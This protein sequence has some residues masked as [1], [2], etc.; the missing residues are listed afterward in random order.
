MSSSIFWQPGSVL[1]DRYELI[2]LV[3]EGG[4]GVVWRV[5]DR[6][7]GRDLALK[8]PR[9]LVLESPILRER[10]VREAETWIGLGVHPHIVQCWFVTEVDGVPA[11]FLDYLTG[12][13]LA[14][15]MDDGHLRPGQ[16]DLIV[17]LAMQAAEGLAYAHSKGVIHRDVKPENLLIRGDER[18][19]VTDFGLVKTAVEEPSAVPA[20]LLEGD[21]GTTYGSAY[22]G[23]PRYAAPEQWGAAQTVTPSADMYALGVTL[24]E[25]C[26][27]RRPFDHDREDPSPADIIRRHLFDPVPDPRDFN[28]SVPPDLAYLCLQML[29]KE[30]AKRPSEMVALR[31]ALH[32]IHQRLTPRVFR[33]AAPL[34]GAQSPDVLNNQAVSLHSLGKSGEAVETL[35]RGLGLDPGHPECL[36]NLVQIEKRSGRIGF[37][38]ALRRLEQARAYYPLALLL[39]EHGL[40]ADALSCLGRVR[41]EGLFS[42]G[43]HHRARGDA[44][45]YLARYEEAEQ[46]YRQAQQH[47]P[48]DAAAE[49]RR[50]LAA[51]RTGVDPAG[52]VCFPSPYAIE[53]NEDTDFTRQV[54]LDEGGE[55]LL[56]LSQEDAVYSPLGAPEKQVKVSRSEDAGRISQTWISSER[57]LLADSQGYEFRGLPSMRLQARREGRLLACAPGMER[58]L[59]DHRDSLHLY[60]MKKGRVQRLPTPGRGPSEGPVLAAFDPSGQRLS[61]LLGSGRLARLDESRGLVLEP[62][63]SRVADHQQARCMACATDGSVFLGLASGKVSCYDSSARAVRFSLDFDQVPRSIEICAGGSRVIVRTTLG[64]FFLLDREGAVLLSGDGP[65]AVAPDD[66]RVLLLSGGEQALYSLDPLHE[67]RRWPEAQTRTAKSVAF[68]GDGRLAVVL[69]VSGSFTVWQ[70]DES[71]RVYQRELLMSP[72]RSYADILSAHQHFHRHLEAAREALDRGEALESHRHLQRARKVPGYGQGGPALDFAW[73]LL[74]TLRRDRLEAVWEQWSV[75][76]PGLG[77]IDLHPDGKHV[78]FCFADRATVAV[79]ED[80]AA[81]TVWTTQLSETICLLRYV[82]RRDRSI[83][84]IAGESGRVT[85]HDADD[86][87]LLDGFNLDGG[88]VRRMLLHPSAITYLCHD[89]SLGQYSLL[90]G[91]HH[92]RAWAGDPLRSFAP[93]RGDKV[94]AATSERFGLLDLSRPEADFEKLQ[95]GLEITKT[96]CFVEYLAERGL[97]VLGFLSGKLR[98]LDV[99]GAGVLA[100]LAHGEGQVVT[101]FALLAELAVAVTTTACGQLVFWDLRSEQP[102]D[103]FEAHREGVSSLRSSRAGRFLLTAGRD[104]LI[105]LWETCWTTRAGRKTDREVPWLGDK[106]PVPRFRKLRRGGTTGKPA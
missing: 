10:Y 97:L 25:M 61:I 99:G 52:A 33:P 64:G 11:L 95:L 42:P 68:S 59:A 30:P 3:G 36:Y 6:E 27:G 73:Q 106:E 85:L 17:E 13:S 93:W 44:L 29:E 98:I 80:G 5:F 67:L 102:L 101:A 8:L 62:W 65:L 47:M 24:F 89:G 75:A 56:I 70:T 92:V 88:P 4:M 26:A 22:L 14:N 57:V 87:S 51:R 60:L 54:L 86:G 63:P 45:M 71:S 77:D 7:W 49:G 48:K 66:Q 46:A 55:G 78:L 84:V 96:P 50:A 23:T 100:T 21:P 76:G 16:W 72:G 43:P 91:M 35:R 12:G 39:L 69:D 40:P 83:V 38:E 37:T 28:P 90:G 15:W 41:P 18:V 81:R 34:L 82:Q 74:G 79:H 2:G 104:G 94:L 103:R 32:R 53:R 1:D 31:Q 20:S 58:V 9:P 105:R 19:C